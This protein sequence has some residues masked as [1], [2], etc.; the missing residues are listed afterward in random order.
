VTAESTAAFS[1]ASKEQKNAEPETVAYQ[2][3]SGDRSP[4]KSAFSLGALTA[5]IV[6]NLKLLLLGPVI[7]AIIAFA[8]LSALPKWYTSVVYLALDESG[9]RVADARM[10]STPVLD[11]VLAG[12]N[13]PQDTLEARRRFIEDSRRIVVAAGETQKTSNLF[14]MEYTDR[15]PLVAQKVN[16]LLI[17]AWLES[18]R[19]PPNTRATIEAEIARTDAQVNSISQLIDRLQKDAPS[20]LVTQ[21]LQGE[22]ATPI[23]GLITKRDQNLAALIT[24]KNSLNGISHDVVFGTPDLPEEPSWPKRGI[25]TILAGSVTGLLLLMFAIFR[26]FDRLGSG[27]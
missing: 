23:L 14:R 3:R 9:A 21:S 8:V 25:I 2:A 27:A 6:E 4:T 19:P 10:R 26:R 22:L 7:A 18:T 20:L 5:I 16:S 12:F 13:A 24:L 1:T 17:E 15:I 11:K